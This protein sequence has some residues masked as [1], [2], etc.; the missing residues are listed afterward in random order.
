L[1]DADQTPCC[2]LINRYLGFRDDMGSVHF[3]SCLIRLSSSAVQTNNNGL[4]TAEQALVRTSL[5][6]GFTEDADLVYYGKK[7]GG[8]FNAQSKEK[9]ELEN[10][11]QENSSSGSKCVEWTDIPIKTIPIMKTNVSLATEPANKTGNGGSDVVVREGKHLQDV[12]SDKEWYQTASERD[13]TSQASSEQGSVSQVAVAGLVQSEGK[14]Q[15]GHQWTQGEKPAQNDHSKT[16]AVIEGP[17]EGELPKL[18]PVRLRSHDPKTPESGAGV[19]FAFGNRSNPDAAP[20]EMLPLPVEPAVFG[21]GSY[22]DV[23]VG[24]DI[25][26]SGISDSEF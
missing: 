15:L 21:L 2:D 18:P 6:P 12:E 13:L 9:S 7:R 14:R 3:A 22:L 4:H 16:T 5:I 17:V 19:G 10:G 1:V 24:Q 11:F 26:S 8:E 20:F 23:P 25:S